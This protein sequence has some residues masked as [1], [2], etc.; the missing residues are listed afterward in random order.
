MSSAPFKYRKV[1]IANRG[2][3]ACRIIRG[4]REMG[5]ATVA[6][7][8]DVDTSAMHVEL[9]DESVHL[10]GSDL[11][12]TY[13]SPTAIIN[14]CRNSGADGLHPGYGFLSERA[15]FAELVE[16]SGIVWIGPPAKAIDSMG[17]KVRARRL[18]IDAGVPLVPGSELSLQDNLSDTVKELHRV[19]GE[20]GFPVLLKASAGGGGKGMRAVDDPGEL[21]AA[22]LAAQREALS[23]FGDDTVYVERRIVS[24]RHI[25]I[26]ILCDTHGNAIHLLER[27]CSIQRRHQKVIEEAPSVAIT[28]EIRSQ[29]GEAAVNAAK[30]VNYVGAGTVEFLLSGN[31]FFFLEMN[32]RLQVE[33]PVTEM[34][35]GVDLVHE[36]LKV[37]SGLPLLLE[38]QDISPR[39][40]SIEARIYSED[41]ANGFLPATGPLAIFRPPEGPG[42]RLDTGVREGDFAGIEFDPMIAK[43]IVH[44]PSR[45][46][47][48]ERMACALS[49]FVILGVITNIE[50][51]R[52]VVRRK[53][54]F[55]GDTTTSFIEDVWPNGWK[56]SSDATTAVI[57]AA[58]A[59]TTGLHLQTASSGGEGSVKSKYN[60]FTSLRSNYP[61]RSKR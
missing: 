2:E 15:D 24:P 3:I 33:H 58:A 20:V 4:C 13:L 14:A 42:I 37:A 1:L 27:E 10:P 28:P 48:I 55:E 8:N 5:L 59:E 50:F 17:D 39:G 45:E 23:A 49:D 47:A 40:W 11:A 18:M 22:Y 61:R 25:E 6:I 31:E 57:V 56:S 16:A 12:S 41:A 60:P 9:A 36:Q 19:A 53:E 7:H 34:V 35:T 32:T 43:L 54:Y 30:A 38:Q 44:A 46:M 52:D 26:Q 51:L 21:E 29:M